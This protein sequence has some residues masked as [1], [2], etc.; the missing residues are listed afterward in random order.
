VHFRYFTTLPISIVGRVVN[1]TPTSFWAKHLLAFKANGIP[2]EI[3]TQE[4]QYSTKKRATWVIASYSDIAKGRNPASTTA[5]TVANASE[6]VQDAN[7]TK[8]VIQDGSNQSD[9]PVSHQGTIS[10]LSNLKRKM[11]EV[12]RE[13]AAFK[14]EQSK[15]EEE[16]STVTCSLIK[17]TEDILDT[18]RDMT[19]VSTS[20]R[21]EMAEIKNM[22]LNMS[23]NKRGQQ[24]L[25][26]KDSEVASTSSTEQGG[27]KY[28]EVYDEIA[29]NMETSWNSMCESKNDIY[30][31]ASTRV[32]QG[33]NTPSQ[34][35]PAGAC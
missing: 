11:E 34:G 21:S 22:I 8:S 27:G 1:Y 17:L 23:A 2:A 31:S 16:V 9:H 33:Y 14:I 15:L 3:D 29:H 32:T 4:L 35:K 30:P 26:H 20:L 12:D 24:Q 13:K 7:S 18:H 19:Q 10:G 28:M 25:K 5:P 6:Q